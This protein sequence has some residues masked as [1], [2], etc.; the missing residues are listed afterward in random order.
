MFYHFCIG[1]KEGARKAASR[2]YDYSIKH[3]IQKKNNDGLLY[4]LEREKKIYKI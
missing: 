3:L 1:F 2:F 4:E